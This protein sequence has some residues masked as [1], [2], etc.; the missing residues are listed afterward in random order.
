MELFRDNANNWEIVVLKGPFTIKTISQVQK[1][2][3]E[4]VDFLQPLLALDISDV[5][6]MDSSAIG[7]ILSA[8]KLFSR[9]GGYIALFG[10]NETISE[11]FETV[12]LG[13][14]VA[15]Y[16]NREEFLART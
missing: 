13:S 12:R 5:P 8:K 4:V 9:K 11:I 7:T 3:D 16:K 1:I 10:A 6:Y 2:V 14:H 15:L